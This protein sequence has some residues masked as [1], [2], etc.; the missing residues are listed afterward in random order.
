MVSPSCSVNDGIAVAVW[1]VGDAA[2]W[3]AHWG[4][5]EDKTSA[6]ISVPQEE[7]FRGSGID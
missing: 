4:H 2:G 3:G 5:N 7:H 1:V 6:G